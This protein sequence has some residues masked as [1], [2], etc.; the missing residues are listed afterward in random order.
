M[1]R[2]EK[3]DLLGRIDTNSFVWSGDIEHNNERG[4]ESTNRGEERVKSHVG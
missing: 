4:G 1:S 2:G 3:S